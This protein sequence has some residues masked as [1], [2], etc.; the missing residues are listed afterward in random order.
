MRLAVLASGC[1]VGAAGLSV[2]DGSACC[3]GC[4]WRI[5]HGHLSFPAACFSVEQNALCRTHMVYWCL[6]VVV[7]VVALVLH[8]NRM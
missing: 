7:V 3:F 2:R 8:S 5:H 4:A 6:R 1:V